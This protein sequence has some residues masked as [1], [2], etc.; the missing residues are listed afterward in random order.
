MNKYLMFLDIFLCGVAVANG[1]WFFKEEKYR[2][3]QMS[4]VAGTLFFLLWCVYG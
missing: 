1:I 4:F 2:A 3:S